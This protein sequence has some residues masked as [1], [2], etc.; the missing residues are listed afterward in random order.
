[1]NDT[2]PSDACP[3][4]HTLPG[5]ANVAR[6]YAI[7]A[8]KYR[9]DP[10]ELTTAVVKR[11]WMEASRERFA[12][13]C[14]PLTMANQAGWQLSCTSDFDAVWDG[15]PEP[16][17]VLVLADDGVPRAS[18]PSGHF[19]EGTIT[20][21]TGY[22]FRTPPG[23]ALLV[24]GPP[25]TDHDG[26]VALTGIVETDWL[27][28][29]FTMN[30]RFTRPGT[31]V[32]FRK[33]DVICSVLPVSL[34][35]IEA[36]K[37]EIRFLH[38]NQSLSEE[39]SAWRLSR[40]SWLKQ[41]AAGDPSVRRAGWQRFYH[42]GT[43]PDG[44]LVR[45]RGSEHRTRVTMPLPRRA[46]SAQCPA[47]SESEPTQLPAEALDTSGGLRYI[48]TPGWR[49]AH[50]ELGSVVVAISGRKPVRLGRSVVHLLSQLQTAKSEAE[51]LVGGAPPET[52][53]ECLDTLLRIGI[54]SA[55]TEDWS[56][57]LTAAQ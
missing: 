14:L 9:D 28:F 56:V 55:L 6:G 19:G 5:T 22:L 35:E 38:E 1:M 46:A 50:A 18:L 21:D 43:G 29:P 52:L 27:P 53:R 2:L 54:I 17:H 44:T 16:G 13:R 11:D 23:T 31:L 41:W 51:L 33:G 49:I 26:I 40:D 8:Y 48:A 32:S 45:P 34:A 37:I 39:M 25:N 36:S 24:S 20:F 12:F 3:A 10:L 15:S 47:G 30:W 7:T 57:Q 4:A 42:R